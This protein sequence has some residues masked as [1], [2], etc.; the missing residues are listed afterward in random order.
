MERCASCGLPTDLVCGCDG[1]KV[2]QPS[3]EAQK[4]VIDHAKEFAGEEVVL[5]GRISRVL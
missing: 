3:E 5:Q 2:A 1:A 4:D